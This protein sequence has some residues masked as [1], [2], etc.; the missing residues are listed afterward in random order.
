MSLQ[1]QIKEIYDQGT[2]MSFS[3]FFIAIVIVS[4]YGTLYANV[5]GKLVQEDATCNPRYVF[6]SGLL[7]PFQKDPWGETEKNFKKCIRTNMYKDPSLSKEIRNNL[8]N[9]QERQREIIQNQ[10]R[11]K[12]SVKELKRQWKETEDRGKASIDE[13]NLETDEVFSSQDTQHGDFAKSTTQLIHLFNYLI[14][15]LSNIVWIR[16]GE[17]KRIL[18]IEERHKVYM[19][20]YR[21][22]Y[23][24]YKASYDALNR[25]DHTFAINKAQ[26]AITAYTKLGADIDTFMNDHSTTRAYITNGCNQLKQAMNNEKCSV[27]FPYLINDGTGLNQTPYTYDPKRDL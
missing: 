11:G 7:N 10:L 14:T 4:M 15:Y 26:K 17:K 23:E 21:E 25:G 6:F 22:I 13:L 8:V 9:I 12:Q 16:L 3:P 5:Q 2:P 1:G 19:K 20:R 24:D 27:I 18:S